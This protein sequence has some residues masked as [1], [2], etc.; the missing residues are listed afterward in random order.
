MPPVLS[1]SY[2]NKTEFLK[3]FC[4]VHM[5][6]GVTGR[7]DLKKSRARATQKGRVVDSTARAA[8]NETAS[9]VSRRV[10]GSTTSTNN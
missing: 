9:G 7:W 8:L 5:V 10:C 6:R 4:L 1:S 2:F 3:S